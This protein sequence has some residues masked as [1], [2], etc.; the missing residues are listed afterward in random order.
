MGGLCTDWIST[1]QTM[2]PIALNN[3]AKLPI[4]FGLCS[5]H[6]PNYI[7]NATI[8]PHVRQNSLVCIMTEEYPFTIGYMVARTLV[9]VLR[10]TWN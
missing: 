2:Q 1:I 9:L 3:G 6:G 7:A 8:F 10:S 4:L 5:Q